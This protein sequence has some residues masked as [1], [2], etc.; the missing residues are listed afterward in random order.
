MTSEFDITDF[1][2]EGKNKIAVLVLKW[3]DGSYLED[4][5]KF[6]MSGI[7]RDVYIIKRPRKAI[8]DYRIETKLSDEI[9]EAKISFEYLT[10]AERYTV[11]LFDK[12]REIAKA[13]IGE[14]TEILF[15]VKNPK[16]W[17]A[18][19]PYLYTVVIENENETIVIG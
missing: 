14:T 16:L 5:D 1:I 18:E 19:C 7:F 15:Q 10:D 13:E 9:A 8:W 4:Q 3:C 17:S 12:E 11:T 2:K 6:R